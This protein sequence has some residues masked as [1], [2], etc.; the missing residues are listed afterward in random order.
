YYKKALDIMPY[1]V[2]ARLGYVYP[3][4]AAGN[5]D[6]VL[7]QYLAVLKIDPQ[8][9]TVNYRTGYLYYNRK[10]YANAQKYFEK[11]VNLYPF[12]Y[13]GV[14]MLGWTYLN[15]GNM[16]DAKILLNRALL[17]SPGDASALEGLRMIK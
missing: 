4:S 12:S 6:K 14:L 17:I 3:L 11:V 1:S 2:E 10:D 7:E 16:K 13:D 9:S 5:W 8:N 15:E